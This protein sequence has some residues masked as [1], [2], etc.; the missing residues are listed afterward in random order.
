MRASGTRQ[1]ADFGSVPVL[2]APWFR[3]HRRDFSFRRRPTPYKVLLAEMLLRKTRAADADRVFIQLHRRYPSPRA[4]SRARINALRAAVRPIGLPGRAVSLIKLGRDLVERHDGR[5]P[6]NRHELLSLPGVGPYSAG[7]ILSLG[8]GIPA[9]MVDGP[10]G[11]VL[12]RISG[13]SNNGGAPYYDK[14]VWA[15]AEQ[16]LPAEGVRDFQ[17]ALLDVGALLCRPAKPLCSECPLENICSYAED[18]G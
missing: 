7:A 11:R 8:F 17:L 12:R 16:L 14:R 18:R 4:L 6:H 5:V 1:T 10:I 15:F 9:P 2:L 13:L 3:E